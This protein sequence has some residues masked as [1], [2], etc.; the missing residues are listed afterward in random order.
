MTTHTLAIKLNTD[1]EGYVTQE[2]GRCH[3]LMKVNGANK[4]KL[5]FCPWCGKK[6]I[7]SAKGTSQAFLTDAQSEYAMSIAK[8]QVLEPAVKQI[9]D[10]FK[11][12]GR[13]PGVKVKSTG[14]RKP[15]RATS[16]PPEKEGDMP[17]HTVSPCCAF[18][19]RHEPESTPVYCGICGKDGHGQE[20]DP[21]D[22]SA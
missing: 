12:L 8:E 2:C 11:K 7:R 9:E 13:L 22:V 14:H 5:T 1:S 4:D 20:V 15:F 19:L 16:A 17:V 10:A 6:P 3:H 18:E 21:Q